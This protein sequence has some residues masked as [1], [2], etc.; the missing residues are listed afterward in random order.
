[1]QADTFATILTLAFLLFIV[2]GLLFGWWR[3]YAKSIVRIG[4]VISVA[5]L[6]FFVVPSISKALL[7]L[8]ISA[9]NIV[10]NGNAATNVQELLIA[11]LESIPY[12]NDLMLASPSFEAVIV[13]LPEIILNLVGFIVFFY[14]FRLLS[15]II[16]WI[17]N[18]IFFSKKKQEGKNK[19]R[20][21]GAVI[22]AVQGAVIAVVLLLPVYGFINTITP[23]IKVE[24][25]SSANVQIVKDYAYAEGEND[26]QGE[27]VSI[28]A[29][30]EDYINAIQNSP[31]TK[32]LNTLGVGKLADITFEKLTTVKYDETELNLKKEI[33]ILNNAYKNIS[34]IANEQIDFTNPEHVQKLDKAIETVLESKNV[35]DIISEIIVGMAEG[36]TNVEDPTFIGISKPDLKD[37][38]LNNA[39]NE[40]LIALKDPRGDVR[41]DIVSIMDAY[42]VLANSDILT[43]TD[44]INTLKQDK[45]E[46][47][48]TN[49]MNEL[50]KSPTIKECLPE[51]LNCA[52]KYGYKTIGF[53]D[54]QTTNIGNVNSEAVI[55]DEEIS[56][57]EKITDDIVAIYD[58]MNNA[59]ADAK[60]YEKVNFATLGNAFDNLRKSNLFGDVSLKLVQEMLATEKFVGEG[61]VDKFAGLSTSL[62]SVWKKEDA[63][64]AQTFKGF[65]DAMKVADKMN[66]TTEDSKITSEDVKDILGSL[67]DN[68]SMSE[69]IDTVVTDTFLQ[70]MG[71]DEETS[72]VILDV[73]DKVINDETFDASKETDAAVEIFNTANKIMNAD[74][75]SVELEDTDQTN[76]INALVKSDSLTQMLADNATKAEGEKNAT[77]DLASQLHDDT[78]AEIIA[79]IEADTE[80]DENKKEQ[81]LA[82]FGQIQSQE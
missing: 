65:E 41:K 22:G 77:L 5:V 73:V 61:N 49:I 81:L 9:L 66:A 35:S 7:T 79:K 18:A 3:G 40:M 62:E 2:L 8:D 13:L 4:L 58:Q 82:I 53:T 16:F 11:L 46:L 38:D 67:S 55:D 44:A 6:T 23:V 28:V 19:H 75:T 56:H 10:I 60:L 74:G 33:K 70:D 57:L 71:V 12:V 30:S 1:M 36:W 47:L 48:I 26:E 43:T 14:L 51:V 69:V 72:G 80:M 37:E 34:F 54:E 31:L 64:L 21:I 63:N 27:L 68:E 39:F 25:I 52:V 45:N 32:V 29:T 15:M 42:V 76:L 20:M 59:S 17:I 50:V 24:T 78:K